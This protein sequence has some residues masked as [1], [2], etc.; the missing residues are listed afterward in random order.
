MNKRYELVLSKE[1]RPYVRGKEKLRVM[2]YWL[3]QPSTTLPSGKVVPIEGP[4]TGGA[5]LHDDNGPFEVV[6][7]TAVYE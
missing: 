3:T 1:R 7:V 5:E 4:Q 2:H 6:A